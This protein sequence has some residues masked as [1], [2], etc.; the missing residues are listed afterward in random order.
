MIRFIDTTTRV[1]VDAVLEAR[2][3]RSFTRTPFRN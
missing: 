1:P 2:F 3:A